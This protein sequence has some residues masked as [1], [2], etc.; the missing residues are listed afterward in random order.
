[1]IRSFD[2]AK[3]KEENRLS[4]EIKQH[5]L[6]KQEHVMMFLS[7]ILLTIPL[8]LSWLKNILKYEKI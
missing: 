2:Y 3:N 4:E 1:M 6:Q 7:Q 8:L 5:D